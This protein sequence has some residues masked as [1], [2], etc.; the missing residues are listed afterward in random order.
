MTAQIAT[1]LDVGVTST[2]VEAI[3]SPNANGETVQDV[4][5]F[6]EQFVNGL[7]K[8]KQKNV[9]ME[10]LTRILQQKIS[11]YRR[12]SI[13]QSKKFSEM[14]QNTASRYRNGMLTSQEVIVAMIEL[15]KQIMAE[16]AEAKKL[17]LN[18]EE[19]AFYRAL[20][21]PDAVKDAYSNEQLCAL[22]R[23][24]TTPCA[25]TGLLIGRRRNRPE[26]TCAESSNDSFAS[27]N[28]RQ[29]RLPMPP[30]L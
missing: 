6:D 26:R 25:R 2:G 4:S 17:G 28:T 10:L 20:T 21:L 23:E 1:I 19:M 13:V 24:L 16:D 11:D 22:T 9:A 27:T 7:K 29:Q 3:I 8:L 30:T 5:I 15:A 14:M 18:E 12:T